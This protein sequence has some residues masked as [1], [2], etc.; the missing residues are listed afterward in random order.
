MAWKNSG[1]ISFNIDPE[2]INEVIEENGNMVTMLR[3]VSWGDKE[4]KI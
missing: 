3:K 4:S 2:G 1:P